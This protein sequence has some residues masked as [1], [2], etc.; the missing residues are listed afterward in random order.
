M[1]V[2]KNEDE[3]LSFIPEAARI[4]EMEKRQKEIDEHYLIDKSVAEYKEIIDKIC[5]ER[6]QGQ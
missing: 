1:P 2:A 4:A 5:K 3:M 6:G